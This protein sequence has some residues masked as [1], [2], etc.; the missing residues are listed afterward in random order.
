VQA[1]ICLRPEDIQLEPAS[2]SAPPARIG[3]TAYLGSLT[4]H[5]VT[6]GPDRQTLRVHVPGRSRYR[7]GDPVAVVLPETPVLICEEARSG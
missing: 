2:A 3:E 6:V 4:E 5:L 7:S 1:I